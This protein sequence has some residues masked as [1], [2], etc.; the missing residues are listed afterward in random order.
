M[1]YNP[2][3]MTPSN[4]HGSPLAAVIFDIGGTLIYPSTTDEHCI[5]QLTAWLIEQDYPDSVGDAITEARHWV[6]SMTAKTGRQYTMQE[7]VRRALERVGA[8]GV[9]PAFIAA[10]ECV[11][12]QPE[13]AGYRTFHGAAR[14]LHRLKRAGLSVGCISNA[15]SHWLIERIV[16][17]MGF[18]PFLDP[19]VSSA[20]FGR[21]KPDPAIFRSVLEA[22]GVTPDRAAMVGDTLTADIGGGKSAGL[23]TLYVTM[24]PSADNVNHPQIRADA[25]ASTLAEAERILL[26]WAGVE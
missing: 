21:A 7:G 18:R 5:R 12:F 24:T 19:V 22:W 14:L 20:G 23:R 17:L 8:G 1:S 2:C 26:D 10:A 4:A 11:F 15:T 13:L 16:D 6:L 9:D 3:V 25:E